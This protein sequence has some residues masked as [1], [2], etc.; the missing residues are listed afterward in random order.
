MNLCD[1]IWMLG[2]CFFIAGIFGFG[3]I[4]NLLEVII[5]VLYNF[6]GFSLILIGTIMT[7]RKEESPQ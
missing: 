2:V 4:D 3:L 1:M 7:R 6:I 5:V